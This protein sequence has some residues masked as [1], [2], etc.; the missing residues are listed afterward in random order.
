MPAERWVL[1]ASNRFEP[2]GSERRGLRRWLTGLR[3]VARPSAGSAM[4]SGSPTARRGVVLSRNRCNLFPGDYAG[5]YPH[6][7]NPAQRLIS[8]R[9]VFVCLQ[10]FTAC[11]WPPSPAVS[12]SRLLRGLGA[13]TLQPGPSDRKQKV[14]NICD[15]N[16]KNGSIA[17]DLL[18]GEQK[19][20]Y[21]NAKLISYR[22]STCFRCS[23]QQETISLF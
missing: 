16:G 10:S 13:D 14:P 18:G 21:H 20:Q 1:G 2:C 22:K 7:A 5:G 6:A 9:G 15:P 11:S 8:Q 4:P 12:P 23:K 3:Q 19:S 17:K